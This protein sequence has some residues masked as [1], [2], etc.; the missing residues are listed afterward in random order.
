MCVYLCVCVCVCVYFSICVCRYARSLCK[1]HASLW[2]IENMPGIHWSKVK[3]SFKRAVP[4]NEGNT[5]WMK[6]RTEEPGFRVKKQLCGCWSTVDSRESRPLDL[7]R[8]ICLIVLSRSG[9]WSNCYS[10]TCESEVAQSCPALCDP[11]D[12]SLPGFSVHGILQARILEW[13]VISFSRRSS[14]PRNWTWVSCTVGRHF[15]VWATREAIPVPIP[16]YLPH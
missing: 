11:M 7:N 2:D 8:S 14:W 6:R 3:N 9:T 1:R 10:R 4:A 15:T 13:V 12:C 16:V 5:I